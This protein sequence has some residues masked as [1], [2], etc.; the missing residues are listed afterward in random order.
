MKLSS[1]SMEAEINSDGILVITPPKDFKGRETLVHAQENIEIFSSVDTGLVKGIMGF[2]PTH[3]IDSKATR[4]YK[5]NRP[6][7]PVA[8]ISDSTIKTMMGNLL[9]AMSSSSAPMKL[10]SNKNDGMVWLLSKINEPK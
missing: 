6:K 5:E 1:E 4:Y 7:L 8:L 10:F 9:L 2:L 3:Y